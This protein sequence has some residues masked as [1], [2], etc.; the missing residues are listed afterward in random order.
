MQIVRSSLDTGIG[1]EDW[2]SGDVYI[3]PVAA[4]PRPSRVSAALVHF[5]LGSNLSPTRNTTGCPKANSEQAS[6]LDFDQT[7]FH[8]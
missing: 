2:F 4:A 1:P 3:D 6:I 5:M 8:T 7:R